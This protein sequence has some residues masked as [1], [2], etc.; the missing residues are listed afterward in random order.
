MQM[1]AANQRTEHGESNGGIRG[2]TEG[3]DGI[4]NPIG[5]TTLSTNQ[6][7]PHTHPRAPRD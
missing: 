6:S 4:C 7:L 3:A 5:R 1:L 2:R